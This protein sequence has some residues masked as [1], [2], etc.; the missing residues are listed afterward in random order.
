MKLALFDL[1]DTLLTVTQ[2]LVDKF[3]TQTVLSKIRPS[4]LRWKSLQTTIEVES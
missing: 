3:W 1:D 4:L 2:K